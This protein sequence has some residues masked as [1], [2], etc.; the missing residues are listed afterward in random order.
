LAV[1]RLQRNALA[2][3]TLANYFEEEP[4]RR[5]ATKLLTGDEAAWLKT[6]TTLL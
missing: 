2:F 4:G 3:A 6:K 1:P 5:S